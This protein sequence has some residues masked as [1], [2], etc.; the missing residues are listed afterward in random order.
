MSTTITFPIEKVQ[1]LRQRAEEARQVSEDAQGWSKS[2]V[3]PMKLLAA[4]SFLSLKK[5]FVLRAYQFQEGGNG[6]GIVWAMPENLTFP[7]TE[8]CLMLKDRFLAPPKPPGALDNIMEAIE[9]DGSPW[10]YLSASLFSREIAEFGAMWHGCNWSTHM[11]LGID[12]LISLQQ[13]DR[14]PSEGPS[15]KPEDWRWLEPTPSEWKPEICEDSNL[16]TVTFYTF[17]GL[18][19]EAI[20]LHLDTYKPGRYCFE[21]DERVIAEGPGGYVF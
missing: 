14:H 2:K 13:S 12:P 3:D 7:E 16:V 9:G 18:G 19:R 8:K 21:S 11:I 1:Q 4:F 20:Y 6:N 17:A 10:S 15:G 5:G